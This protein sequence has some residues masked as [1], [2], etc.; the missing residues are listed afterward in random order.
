MVASATVPGNTRELLAELDRLANAQF[1]TPEFRHLFAVP[2]TLP[3]ARLYTIQMTHFV[4]NRRDVWAQVQ[5]V[6]PLDVKRLV[7]AHESEE[8][9]HDARAGTDHPT[10]AA[11]ESAV[12][13][14]TEED[15]VNAELVPG[16]VAA[17]WA[18]IHL[19]RSRPWL[20]VFTASSVME[21]R[22][23][24]AIV[25][26]GGVSARMARKMSR[27][28]GIPLEQFS[29]AVVHMAADVEHASLMEQVAERY[30][31]TEADRRAILRATHETYVI[32]RAFRAAIAEA[33][34]DLP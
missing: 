20:E 14:V 9:V 31:T 21:R 33:M 11:R 24:D 17:F 19:A 7:C 12:L 29:N 26:G 8:L 2:M 16:V 34:E 5:A 23:S 27:E 4:W 6:V 28:L 22:N 10:L 15:I 3:R 1:E 18:W 13:G 30:A 25:S 32:D